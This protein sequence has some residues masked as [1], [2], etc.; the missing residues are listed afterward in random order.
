MVEGIPCV[1]ERCVIELRCGDCGGTGLLCDRCEIS[2]E[3]GDYC[4]H[5]AE[6]LEQEYMKVQQQK[7]TVTDGK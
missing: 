2:I 4:D 3:V 7:E 5:C 6:W 1:E